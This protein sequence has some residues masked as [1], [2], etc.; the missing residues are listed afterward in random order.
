MISFFFSSFADCS[1]CC[2][3]S[4]CT[5]KRAGEKKTHHFTLQI[6]SIRSNKHIWNREKKLL[7][8]RRI[9]STN[10]FIQIVLYTA[11][12][13]GKSNTLANRVGALFSFPRFTHKH[14]IY[15]FFVVAQ[16][17]LPSAMYRV[18][19]N[20][21][22]RS[23]KS[24]IVSLFERFMHTFQ[25]NALKHAVNSGIYHDRRFYS[26]FSL[27]QYCCSSFRLAILFFNHKNE[28][29]FVNQN[30]RLNHA[31]A[32][33]WKWNIRFV[34]ARHSDNNIDDDERKKRLR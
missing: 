16:Q 22:S 25:L 17:Q 6:D 30:Y 11:N 8:N 1:L 27:V 28:I 12:A 13:R 34:F 2:Y 19:Q 18:Q 3:K 15:F 9:R 5:A 31:H 7:A 32:I 14:K 33:H 20:Y 4:T 21:K 26:H 29:A 23:T 10:A 24:G